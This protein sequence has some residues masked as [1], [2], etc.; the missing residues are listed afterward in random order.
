MN[1]NV[2]NKGKISNHRVLKEL[3]TENADEEPNASLSFSSFQ[4]FY[5][6]AAANDPFLQN[7]L[8]EW[9]RRVHRS[10]KSLL[11]C[12]EDVQRSSLCKHTK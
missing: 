8:S 10:G 7:D 2:V 1:G 9:V 6:N 5:G 12:P 3:C 11:C 4:Q